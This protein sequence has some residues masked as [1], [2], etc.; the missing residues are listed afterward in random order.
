MSKRA[1]QCNVRKIGGP[2]N[3]EPLLIFCCQSEMVQPTDVVVHHIVCTSPIL[4]T[5]LAEKSVAVSSTS[6]SC[7]NGCCCWHHTSPAPITMAGSRPI[8][9]LGAEQQSLKYFT[10]PTSLGGATDA[11]AW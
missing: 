9:A 8:M 11:I 7:K 10:P 2:S 3:A 1:L 4:H 5:G 6:S